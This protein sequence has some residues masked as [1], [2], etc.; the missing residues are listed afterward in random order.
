MGGPLYTFYK[1]ITAIKLSKHLTERYDDY[2]FVPVF[3]LEGDDHDFDEVTWI[4]LL[5]ENNELVKI[6]YND[7]APEDSNRGSVVYVKLQNTINTF[8]EEMNNNLRGTDFTSEIM[9]N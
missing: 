2:N 9:E 6:K 5:N 3:W 1:I 8:F 4:N 7:N